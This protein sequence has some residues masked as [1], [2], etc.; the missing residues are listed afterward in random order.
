MEVIT[1]GTAAGVVL[2]TF[3]AA[4][5]F[6]YFRKKNISIKEVLKISGPWFLTAVIFAIGITAKSVFRGGEIDKIMLSASVF[7]LAAFVFLTLEEE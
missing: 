6:F 3:A 5:G 1:A 7:T 4:A 2:A